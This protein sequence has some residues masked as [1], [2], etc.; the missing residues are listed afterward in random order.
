MADVVLNHKALQMAL[1]EFDIVEVDPM[2][3]TRFPLSPSPFK[4]WTKFTLMAEMAP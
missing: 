2:I 3:E 4:R 1:E